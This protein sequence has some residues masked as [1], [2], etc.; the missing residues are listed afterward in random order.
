MAKTL[1]RVLDGEAVWPPPLWLMRQ[2]GRYLPEYRALRAKAADFIA[3]CT[4]PRLAVEATLQPLRRFGFDAAILFSDILLLPW[5]LGVTLAYREGEGPVLAPV[6]DAA[7]LASLRPG[8]VGRL[9]PVLETVAAARAAVGE[10]ALIGFAGGPFTVACYLVEGR[11]SRDWA[12]LR[13]VLWQQPEL[14][15]R[16]LRMLTEETI[17]YLQAQIDAGAEV[18]MLF[19]S[20]AGL[21]AASLF[22]RYV[23]AVTAEIAAR[24]AASHPGVPLIAFPR[25]ANALLAAFA[26]GSGAAAVGVDSGVDLPAFAATLGGRPALQGNIDPWALLAGG[27]AL[28]AE[29]ASLLAGMRGRPFICNLGHGVLPATP[30][31]HVAALR[32]AVAA[33]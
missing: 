17:A 21:L 22:R 6:R 25:G 4:T 9:G 26:A 12:A 2:A 11:A 24:L 20:W 31:A 29:T 3:F 15:A 8:A 32:A 10:A 23:L 13:A 14:F 27:P 30:L 33:G 28:A 1:L 19:D 7:A 5:A 18:V 16:L